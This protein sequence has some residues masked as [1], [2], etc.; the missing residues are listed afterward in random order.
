MPWWALTP[1][2]T[3]LAGPL[4]FLALKRSKRDERHREEQYQELSDA[5]TRL[6]AER[7]GRELPEGPGDTDQ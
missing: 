7:R 4:I 5:Y 1:M 3:V 6:L 2:I